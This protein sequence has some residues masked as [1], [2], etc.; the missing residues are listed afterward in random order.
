MSEPRTPEQIRADIEHTREEL[1]D[2]AAALAEKAD[3]KARAHEKV[4][5]TKARAQVKVEE[6]KARA[7]VKVEETKARAQEKVEVTKARVS[8]K[9]ES[10][11]TQVQANPMPP[12]LVTAAVLGVVV[13]LVIA[14]RRR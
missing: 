3:V 10:T 9:L 7:Q 11:R 14:R 1:A 8:P 6:T 12:A 5:E 2:T 4:E 13:G